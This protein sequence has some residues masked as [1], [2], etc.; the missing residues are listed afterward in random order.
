MC[1]ITSSVKCVINNS[2]LRVEA[3]VGEGGVTISVDVGRV[4][5]VYGLLCVFSVCWSGCGG[6]VEERGRWCQF[7][8]MYSLN[9]QN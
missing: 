9:S 3:E 2:G 4:W 7:R 6:D 8:R 1:D 5:S